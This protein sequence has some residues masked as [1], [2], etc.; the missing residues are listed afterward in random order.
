MIVWLNVWFMCSVFVMFG[1]G[2]WI[3]KLG[4]DGLNV[5]VV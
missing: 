1:G 2:N 4:W 3:V 5:G